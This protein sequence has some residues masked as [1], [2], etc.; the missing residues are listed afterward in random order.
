MAMAKNIRHIPDGW[1]SQTIGNLINEQAKSTIKVSEASG[2][3]AYPFFTSGDDV[4]VHH[5][6][7]IDGEN[8]YIATGGQANAKYYD[9]KAAYSTDTYVL[10][11]R[12]S[13]NT[14]LFFFNID[15]LRPYI[16]AIYFQGSGLKHLQKKDFKRYE[17]LFPKN[18]EE[19]KHI[20][21]LLNNI[22]E[23][24]VL[25]E[26]LIEKY[27]NVKRGMMHD[28]LTCGI[29][30]DGNIRSPKTHRFKPSPLGMIPEEWEC[31]ELGSMYNLKSGTTP[32]RSVTKY[33]DPEGMLW[34]KTLDLNEGYINDTDEKVSNEALLSTSLSIQPVGAILVA[35]YGGWH[36]IGRTAVLASPATT[37]P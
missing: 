14:R 33:F 10:K 28:L 12:D 11:C 15:T 22:D 16:E 26:A 29:D 35:M 32:N 27:R 3:G 9:G 4:L 19:Q 20:V 23:V 6:A 34:V 17:L 5:S 31:V 1:D 2:F 21:R 36:Q 13:I 37:K 25:T 7:L 24:I 18:K 8:V 30:K